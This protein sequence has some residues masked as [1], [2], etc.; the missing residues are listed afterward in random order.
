MHRVKNDTWESQ[1]KRVIV[2]KSARGYW[3]VNAKGKLT[4]EGQGGDKK[5]P[6]DYMDA[7]VGLIHLADNPTV[8]TPTIMRI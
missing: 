6:D 4:E 7:T 8:V 3:L 1:G 2:T 5:E